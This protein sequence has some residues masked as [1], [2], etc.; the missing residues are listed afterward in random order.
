MKE[1]N[2]IVFKC[3]FCGYEHELKNVVELHE[4][5]C[6]QNPINQ[7]CSTCTNQV[8]GLGCSKSV[9]MNCVGGDVLCFHY[10]AGEP[11]NPMQAILQID[12]NHTDPETH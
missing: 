1:I 10:K 6:P 8:L 7:P 12:G 5:C 9:D 2:K 11:L 3:D 4:L